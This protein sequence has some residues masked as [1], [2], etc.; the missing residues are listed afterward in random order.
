MCLIR[1]H[2][3]ALLVALALMAALPVE[4]EVREF[5]APE[6]AGYLVSPCAS[7][8]GICGEQVADLWCREQGFERVVDWSVQLGRD[9]STATITL[10]GGAICRGAQCESFASISCESRGRSFPMPA[11]GGLARSTLIAP[12]RRSAE[13]AAAAVQYEVS[14][15]GCQQREPGIFVCETLEEYG[16]C[17]TLLHSGKVFGCRAGL[18]FDDAYAEPVAVAPDRYRMELKSDAEITVERNRRGEGKIRGDAR[19]EIAFAMP[20]IDAR[21]WCLRRD[22][23]VY[24]LS[25]PDG[26]LARI[27]DTDDCDVPVTGRFEPHE[28]DL[29]EAYDLCEA[30][31]SWGDDL[32]HGIERLVAALFHIGSARP[33]FVPTRD[34]A[35]IVAPYVKVRAPLSI[36]CRE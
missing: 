19:F 11:L 5:E 22:R 34:R 12:D 25:G 7:A 17:R 20:D 4:A 35:R 31:L 21:D 27:D 9:F 2:V 6:H 13:L 1:R 15:S 10:D 28:D 30:S 29:I 14:I 3:A 24:L 23:Y 8:N 33:D 32:Q 16:Q 18:S 26:G 36:R